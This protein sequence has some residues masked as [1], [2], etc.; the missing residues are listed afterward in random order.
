MTSSA[1]AL[2]SLTVLFWGVAALFDKL[3]VGLLAPR[4]VFFARLY[5]LFVLLL[6]PMALSW[7]STRQAMFRADKRAVFYVIGSVVFA[8]GGIYLYFHALSRGEASR[9]V[10]F[11]AAYPMVTFVLA[12]G[13]LK[14]PLSYSALVGT[15]LVASGTI[16]LS[17]Q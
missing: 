3:A 9:V 11:C 4:Q 8:M 17:K 7:E 10:P 12:L 13:V 16:L 6:I 15:L 1:L 14:E 5:V 2:A